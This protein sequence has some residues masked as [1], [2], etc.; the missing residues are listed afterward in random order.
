MILR[1]DKMLAHL[2]YGSRKDVKR[3]IRKGEVIVNGEVCKN[4]DFKVDSE[5]DEVIVYA[6]TTKN[7]HV[8]IPEGVSCVKGQLASYSYELSEFIT[9]KI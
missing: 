3:I 8:I 4:D 1:L 6:V 2:G 5:N 7:S 9:V